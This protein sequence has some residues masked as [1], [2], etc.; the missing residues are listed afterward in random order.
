M[1]PLSSASQKET[2][3]RVSRYL[4]ETRTASWSTLSGVSPLTWQDPPGMFMFINYYRL[5]G[6]YTLTT[7]HRRSPA[8]LCRLPRGD[9]P[10]TTILDTTYSTSRGHP[11]LKTIVIDFWSDSVYHRG[12]ALSTTSRTITTYTCVARTTCSCLG[13]CSDSVTHANI[14]H[15]RC[16]IC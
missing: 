12:R 15:I 1:T 3:T 7:L 8:C 9:E 4:P 16:I 10:G 2:L 6:C 5:E 11:L 13:F 14:K